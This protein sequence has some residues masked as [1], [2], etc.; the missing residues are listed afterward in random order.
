MA[1]P[2]GRKA[3]DL[4]RARLQVVGAQVRCKNSGD[5]LRAQ[6]NVTVPGELPPLGQL[7]A[8]LLDERRKLV[9]LQARGLKD[10]V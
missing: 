4:L 6:Y 5:G 2:E 3:S 7:R 8:Q 9:A 1:G 10:K